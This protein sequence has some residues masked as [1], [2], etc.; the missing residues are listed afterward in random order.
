MK[1]QIEYSVE[2]NQNFSGE[3]VRPFE[4][5][6]IEIK[7]FFEIKNDPDGYQIEIEIHNSIFMDQTG[8][9]HKLVKESIAKY[10]PIIQEMTK[11]QVEN[12]IHYY[13]HHIN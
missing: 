10:I 2:I 1:T 4:N 9:K 11:D 3:F 7:Y 5:D 6:Y 13:E 12:E 8:K